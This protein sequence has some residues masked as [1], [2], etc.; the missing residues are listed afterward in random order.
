MCEVEISAQAY[1]KMRL[2][3]A[4]YPHCAVNGILLSE[5][6]KEGQADCICVTDCIPLFHQCLSLTVMWEVALNQ[7]ELWSAHKH[8][9]VAGYYQANAILEDKSPNMAAQ[10]LAGR[11]SDYF[12]DAVLIMLDNRKLSLDHGVPPVVVFERKDV[13]WIPKDKNLIMWKDWE[14][15]RRVASALTESKAYNQLV[16][17][18]SHL[19]DI[20]RD[21]ANEELNAKITELTST[22]NGGT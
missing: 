14:E 9:M 8:Q 4:R 7:I 5:R 19:D 17:F 13:H 15:T 21:W 16:D 6:R 1:V 20:R 22:A 3:A 2:H 12:K 18:D 11:I 10:K